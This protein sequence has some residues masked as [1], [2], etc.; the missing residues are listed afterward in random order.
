MITDIPS[1]EDFQRAGIGFLNLSWDAVIDIIRHVH[2]FE[3]FDYWGDE[4]RDYW[5]AA[6]G[7][8]ATSLALSQQGI[9]LLVKAR[10]AE[11]SPFLLLDSNW[12]KGHD[13]VDTPFSEFRT[14]DS[15]DLMRAYDTIQ[16]TRLPD[17]FKNRVNELRRLR[18]TVFHTVDKRMTIAAHDVLFSIL[19][20]V[21]YLVAPRSWMKTRREYLNE[22]H[23]S[24]A[25]SSDHVDSD[26]AI[27]A[28][29]VMEVFAPADIFRFLG[30]NKKQRRYE[31]YNCHRACNEYS[32][33][34]ECKFAVLRPNNATATKVFCAICE[35]EET[36]ERRPC[37]ANGCKGNVIHSDDNLCLT[38]W[39][40]QDKS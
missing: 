11:V 9:E 24:M 30:I 7:V 26:I 32:E 36:V 33:G 20:A 38:C 22:S 19:D 34:T 5:K 4:E 28:A 16:K 27:E 10:I 1:A 35:S 2:V 40:D 15:Q 31:C 18:N 25:Y 14:I 37:R 29:T 21:H 3:E 6:Q 12:C 13:K 8:L 39:A 17:D 23:L